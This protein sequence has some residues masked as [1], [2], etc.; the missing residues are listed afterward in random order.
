LHTPAQPAI[1]AEQY[2]STMLETID[3]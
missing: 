2:S 1:A 3:G